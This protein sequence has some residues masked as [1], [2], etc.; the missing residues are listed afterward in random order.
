M[1]IAVK[2]SFGHQVLLRVIRH[3]INNS[4]LSGGGGGGGWWRES[5]RACHNS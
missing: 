5:E 3:Y 2:I 4:K 1:D